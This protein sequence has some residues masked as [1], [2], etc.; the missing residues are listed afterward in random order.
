[1]EDQLTRQ[2]KQNKEKTKRVE[3]QIAQLQQQTGDYG[4]DEAERRRVGSGG[5]G[6]KTA[7]WRV[8]VDQPN[9]FKTQNEHRSR[10]VQASGVHGARS[11]PTNPATPQYTTS[12]YMMNHPSAQLNTNTNKT[13]TNVS[14]TRHEHNLSAPPNAVAQRRQAQADR[15][16][17]SQK[18]TQQFSAIAGRGTRL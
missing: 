12:N 16:L 7:P 2:L 11:N 1:M 4:A 9:P 17:A 14:Q 3:Q 6:G 10:M 18:N 15:Y 13:T 5:D 8:G